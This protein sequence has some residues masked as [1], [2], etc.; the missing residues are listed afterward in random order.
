M[1][2]LK[3]FIPKLYAPYAKERIESIAQLNNCSVTK[4]LNEAD[5]VFASHFKGSVKGTAD[6]NEAEAE[7]LYNRID[8]NR[9]YINWIYGLECFDSK[10]CNYLLMKKLYERNGCSI[11]SSSLEII[12]QQYDLTN[13]EQCLQFQ[14]SSDNSR[15]L[16]KGAE[17]QMGEDIFVIQKKDVDCDSNKLYVTGKPL[18][19]TAKKFQAQRL[20]MPLLLDGEVS[21]FRIYILVFYVK[22]YGFVCY[23]YHPGYAYSS[24]KKFKKGDFS[25]D[26]ILAN[27]GVRRGW[28]ADQIDE[29]LIKQKKIKKGESFMNSMNKHSFCDKVKG[30]LDVVMKSFLSKFKRDSKVFALLGCD[31]L[32]DEQ[33]NC[34][35]IDPNI[36]ARLGPWAQPQWE[37]AIKLVIG[38]NEKK[39]TPVVGNIRK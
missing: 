10:Q 6:F 27:K 30:I 22:R 29:E 12:P 34:F 11:H 13:R 32:V 15:Y 26:N 3:L 28:E 18:N 1:N 23:Y 33:F 7:Y 19:I 8:H 36:S 4:Q 21:T 20:V 35:W 37:S 5:V 24:G 14:R 16:A 2:S 31:V 38:A 17:S 25:I 39:I 9:Q